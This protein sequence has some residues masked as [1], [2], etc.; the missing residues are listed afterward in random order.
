MNFEQAKIY[1]SEN[2]FKNLVL[3]NQRCSLTARDFQLIDS[4]LKNGVLTYLGKKYP[5]TDSAEVNKK[6]EE[7]VH[8]VDNIEA[9]ENNYMSKTDY[10]F[11]Y[12]EDGNYNDLIM[13]LMNE[14]KDLL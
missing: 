10:V 4:H 3:L 13:K 8:E 2:I 12:R 1:C 14:I 5:L 11:E 9:L 7:I 6:L